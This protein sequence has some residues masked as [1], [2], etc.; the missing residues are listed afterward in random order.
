MDNLKNMIDYIE[1][2]QSKIDDEIK[3]NKKASEI[4]QQMEDLKNNLED[5]IIN[6]IVKKL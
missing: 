2:N 1:D 5:I 6:N 3:D 4:W